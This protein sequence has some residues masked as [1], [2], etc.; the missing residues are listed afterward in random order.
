MI[1]ALLCV[2]AYLAGSIP[3][4]I[5]AARARGVDLRKVGGGNIGATNVGARWGGPGPSRC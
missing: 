3:T 4:G 2:G 5:L 1:A